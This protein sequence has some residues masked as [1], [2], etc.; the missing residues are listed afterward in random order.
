MY[1]SGLDFHS[2]HDKHYHNERNNKENPTQPLDININTHLNTVKSFTLLT[3]CSRFTQHRLC[4][5]QMECRLPRKLREKHR[6]R[7]IQGA[8]M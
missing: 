6:L 7:Y 2:Y 8:C 1:L 4:P 3:L 5:L